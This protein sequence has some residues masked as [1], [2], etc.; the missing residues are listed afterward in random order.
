VCAWV[1]MQIHI[2]R[3]EVSSWCHISYCDKDL[4]ISP[5]PSADVI[6]T[7]TPNFYISIWHLNSDPHVDTA[8]T[9]F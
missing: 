5:L 4:F 7:V 9:Y 2:M 8:S 1:S 3:P 6:G